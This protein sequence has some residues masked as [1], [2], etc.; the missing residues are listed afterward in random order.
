MLTSILLCCQS[1]STYIAYNNLILFIFGQN[2]K[3]FKTAQQFLV[4]VNFKMC[5]ALNSLVNHIE[6]QKTVIYE[7]FLLIILPT[8]IRPLFSRFYIK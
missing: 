7:E 3:K 1:Q 6:K 4:Y 5:Y 8:F 2:K